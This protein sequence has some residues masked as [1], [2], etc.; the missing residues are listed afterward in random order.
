MVAKKHC[1]RVSARVSF[2]LKEVSEYFSHHMY[3]Y[4]WLLNIFQL[5]FK[6]TMHLT[7]ITLKVIPKY[8]NWKLMWQSSILM[9]LSIVRLNGFS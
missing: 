3:F 1:P 6:K 9:K 7:E 2:V 8:L 4:S 5:S